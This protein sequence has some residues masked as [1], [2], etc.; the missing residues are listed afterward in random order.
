MWLTSRQGYARARTLLANVLW[1]GSLGMSTHFPVR[2]N[3]QPWYGQRMPDASLRPKYMLAPRCGQASA[4]APTR[5]SL[6]RNMTRFSPSRRMRL[7]VPSGSGNSRLG[8][9]GNQY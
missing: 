9:A 7:M 6:S 3:F 1:L 4:S 8:S 5:P 2:S